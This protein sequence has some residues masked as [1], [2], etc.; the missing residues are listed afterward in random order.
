MSPMSQASSYSGLAIVCVVTFAAAFADNLGEDHGS[1]YV[2]VHHIGYFAFIAL[3]HF[4]NQE[5]ASH[6][7]LLDYFINEIGYFL[8][9]FGLF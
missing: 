6:S 5:H 1:G 8:S 3:A 4:T 7:R 9:V 2:H